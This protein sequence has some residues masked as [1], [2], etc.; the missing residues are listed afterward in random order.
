[1]P[2]SRQVLQT[3]CVGPDGRPEE[4]K[5]RNIERNRFLPHREQTFQALGSLFDFALRAGGIKCFSSPG[6]N[7]FPFFHV[8]SLA[9]CLHFGYSPSKRPPQPGHLGILFCRSFFRC[10]RCCWRRISESSDRDC[11]E[12]AFP[13]CRL[14]ITSQNRNS[15]PK[16]IPKTDG[17][18]HILSASK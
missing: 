2:R 8:R 18:S 16:G 14:C 4:S 10:S 7:G 6:R 13:F 12:L 1:M 15:A 3:A 5:S 17:R 11:S 9:Q